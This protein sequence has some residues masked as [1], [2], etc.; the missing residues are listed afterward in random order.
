M[1]FTNHNKRSLFNIFL[2]KLESRAH[3]IFD[4]IMSLFMKMCP[5]FQNEGNDKHQTSMESL[6]L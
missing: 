3:V 4:T 2:N 1:Y 5:V 6:S